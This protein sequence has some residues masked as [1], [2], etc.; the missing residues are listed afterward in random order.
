MITDSVERKETLNQD[1]QSI[2]RLVEETYPANVK[3]SDGAQYASMFTEDA[4]WMPPD[5]PDF[6][7]TQEIE[8]EIT[9]RFQQFTIN[10]TVIAEEIEVVTSDF[11]YVVG[12]ASVILQP[13]DGSE[14]MNMAFRPVWLLRKEDSTWKIARQIWNVKP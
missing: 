9:N 5:A 2:K 1:V 10:P 11:A 14:S 7:G 6:R 12:K 3:S 4:L 8:G 13:K